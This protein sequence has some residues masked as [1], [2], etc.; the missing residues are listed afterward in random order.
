[1]LPHQGVVV[2]SEM[3][4]EVGGL[5]SVRWCAWIRSVGGSGRSLRDGVERAK[6][7][8]TGTTRYSE[9]VTHDVR[10]ACGI[11]VQYDRTN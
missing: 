8:A 2:R 3:S 5:E 1:M 4:V 6:G 7:H 9:I 11:V 10:A